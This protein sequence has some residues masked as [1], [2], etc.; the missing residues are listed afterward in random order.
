MSD[1]LRK[2]LFHYHRTKSSPT[3]FLQAASNGNGDLQLQ[4]KQLQDLPV[5]VV[6]VVVEFQ[7]IFGRFQVVPRSEPKNKFANCFF[8][9]L[10]V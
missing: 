9:L 4:V 3:S 1:I 5:L 2:L 10:Q 7:E 6:E 8:F